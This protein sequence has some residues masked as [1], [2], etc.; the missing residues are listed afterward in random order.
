LATTWITAPIAAEWAEVAPS[1]VILWC[2]KYGIGRKVGGRWRIDPRALAAL[3][4]GN[5][6]VAA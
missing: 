5:S 2:Q 3:L 1:T 6:E 4:A